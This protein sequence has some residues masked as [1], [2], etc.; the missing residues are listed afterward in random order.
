MAPIT[1]HVFG[2]FKRPCFFKL[3]TALQLRSAFSTEGLNSNYCPRG[4][5]KFVAPFNTF[6]TIHVFEHMPAQ[7]TASIFTLGRILINDI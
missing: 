3:H 6:K 7:R 1:L 2:D 4:G 5:F